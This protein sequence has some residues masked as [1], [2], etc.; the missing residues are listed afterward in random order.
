MYVVITYHSFPCLYPLIYPSIKASLHIFC[1]IILQFKKKTAINASPA[2][3]ISLFSHLLNRFLFLFH[4][5][6]LH[7]YENFYGFIF[8]FKVFE[9]ICI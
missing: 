9:I 1:V 7:I 5:L 6:I 4:N 8:P 2:P 3:S